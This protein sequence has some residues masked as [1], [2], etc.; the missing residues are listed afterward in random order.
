MSQRTC[1]LTGSPRK[2]PC[3][4][5]TTPNRVTSSN[6]LLCSIAM[7]DKKVE[8]LHDRITSQPRRH[9]GRCELEADYWLCAMVG[10]NG[11]WVLQAQALAL[12]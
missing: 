5:P 7:Q 3:A 6:P 4:R 11:E 10:G 2:N 12:R 9:C 1:V 8:D